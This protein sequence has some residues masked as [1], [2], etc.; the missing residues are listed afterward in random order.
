MSFLQ[1]FVTNI[2]IK[3]AFYKNNLGIPEKCVPSLYFTLINIIKKSYF[4]PAASL[5]C[6]SC[7]K[8]DTGN[9]GAKGATG[10]GC[11]AEAAASFRCVKEATGTDTD[12]SGGRAFGVKT[13]MSEGSW[14]FSVEEP[15]ALLR[16][17]SAISKWK[18][19]KRE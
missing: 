2:A 12:M 10:N 9:G 14:P 13:D 15:A 5:R 8:G 7:V 6:S 18:M 17:A 19:E 1:I 16:F 3:A 4:V 11:V